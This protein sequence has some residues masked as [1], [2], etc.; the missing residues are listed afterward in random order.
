M[1]KLFT[2]IAAFVASVGL[3]QAQQVTVTWSLTESGDNQLK[4]VSSDA[5]VTA[6]KVKVG[7]HLTAGEKVKTYTEGKGTL[8][9]PESGDEMKTPQE[10]YDLVFSFNVPSG[11]SFKPTSLSFFS[12]A[13]GS[14]NIHLLDVTI[15]DGSSIEKIVESYQLGRGSSNAEVKT[16]SIS[17]DTAYEGQLNLTF[18]L[19]GKTGG[20]SKG[21][22][23]GDVVVTG[24]LESLSDTRVSAPISWNPEEVTLKIRD[25]F[26][27][28][29]LVNNEKLPVTFSSSNEDLATVSE[30]GKITLKEGVEGTAIITATYDGSVPGAPYKTT[31]VN[32]T[33]TVNTNITNVSAW[34]EYPK[35]ETIE[36]SKM[37]TADQTSG[38]LEKESSLLEDDNISISTVFEAKY[39]DYALN[40]LGYEFKGAAQLSRVTDAPSEGTL[41]GTE[42]SGNSPLIVTPKSD[43]QLVMFFRRQSVEI[44]TEDSDNVAENVIT[45]THYMGMKP[46]DK[47]VM[48]SSHDDIATTIYPELTFGIPL[49]FDYLTCAAIFDLKANVTY[50]IW[51]RGTTINLNAIGYILPDASD[52]API[53]WSASSVK[54]KVRDNLDT[55]EL[56]TL[57]NEEKL[58]VTYAS[59]NPEIASIDENGK[60]TLQNEVEGKATISATYTGNK[61]VE[62][63]VEYLI[64]VVSNEVK[65]Y[66][67]AAFDPNAT[68][69]FN[70]LW[71]APTSDVSA[72]KLIDDKNIE[73]STVYKAKANKNYKGT[74]FGQAYE[75]SLQIGRVADAP[76]EGNLT[77]TENSDSSPLVVKPQT[78][79]QLVVIFR[80]QGVEIGEPTVVDNKEDN[81]ITTSYVIGSL[82]NDKKSLFAANQKDVTTK[83]DQTIIDGGAY[84]GKEN[85]TGSNDYLYTAV[86]WDLKGGETYTI[87]GTGSTICVNGIGYILPY[88]APE[89]PEVKVDEETFADNTIELTGTNKVV[90]IS[91]S[92]EGNNVYYRF[93][94]QESGVQTL[95]AAQTIM[96]EGKEYTLVPENGIELSEAGTLLFLEHDPSTDLRSEVSTIKVTGKGST[97]GINGIAD[98]DTPVEYYDLQGK[99]VANPQNGIYIRR[100][101]NNVSKVVVR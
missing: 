2:L 44:R 38:N 39:T 46:N 70:Y 41:T 55:I 25:P 95:A 57:K 100:Q 60:V 81:V 34:E 62:T 30:D 21:W 5:K 42:N 84:D 51:T 67:W 82:P 69:K 27:S 8:F 16:S 90:K 33:I 89:A 50:T 86:V 78:D 80:K 83:L 79:L 45:R 99:R 75:S 4:G 72:G 94:A 64:N 66:E 32:T 17:S 31:N 6:S 36:V 96:H 49:G 91:A 87:W 68:F 52:K 54:Y 61:Y 56:P 76:A 7:S 63:T 58:E 71:K 92:N 77:G 59:S 12:A 20:T 10:G 29:V 48:A 23:L 53:S 14:G 35:V 97:T 85:A 101:G 74:F 37:W 93:E 19:Y 22:A 26:T 1:K 24:D 73:V 11:Y 28:P 43:L 18:D 65:A 3:M 88:T 9:S 98:A 40:Y 13:D 47:G 15:S